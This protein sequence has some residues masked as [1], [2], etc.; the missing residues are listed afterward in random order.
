MR[1]EEVNLPPQGPMWHVEG[2]AHHVLAQTPFNM[3]IEDIRALFV[4]V[5]QHAQE[6]G[7]VILTRMRFDAR[8]A[9][10][11][12]E[13]LRAHLSLLGVREEHELYHCAA[14]IARD[15]FMLPRVMERYRGRPETTAAG[16][17]MVAVQVAKAVRL[18]QSAAGN[19]LSSSLSS[20]LSSAGANV[21]AADQAQM[22]P[23]DMPSRLSKSLDMEI[24]TIKLRREQKCSERS[25]RATRIKQQLR[26]LDCD[27][28]FI[29]GIL[30]PD[31]CPR[32]QHQQQ[33][34]QQSGRADAEASD[35]SQK[36]ALQQ[37]V[38]DCKMIAAYDKELKEL[39]ALLELRRDLRPSVA[40]ALEVASALVELYS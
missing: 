27:T 32:H 10:R 20:S 15:V 1:L 23:D 5:R 12:H 7:M 28:G 2:A 22:L 13:K 18:Q 14:D 40:G 8:N 36:R 25:E 11:V 4:A 9:H 35:R 3:R 30:P 19:T 21:R 38:E 26:K 24:S 17:L 16:A 6:V 39:D 34:Q 33:H 37:V 31:L 29:E